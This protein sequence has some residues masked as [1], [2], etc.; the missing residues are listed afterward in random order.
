MCITIA[1]LSGSDCKPV[2]MTGALMP[3]VPV[4]LGAITVIP[5]APRRNLAPSS[6]SIPD[7]IRVTSELACTFMLTKGGT[8]SAIDHHVTS[9]FM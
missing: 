5:L 4:T 3:A 6:F 8:Y 2:E 7:V 1:E 9:R